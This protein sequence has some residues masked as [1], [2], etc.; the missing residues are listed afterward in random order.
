MSIKK[1]PLRENSHRGIARSAAVISLAALA[2]RILGFTRDMVIA[3]MF[4]IYV[5]AQAF[6]IAFKI[7]NLFRD[8]LAEGASNAAV[9][10]VL[11]EYAGKR[12]REEFWELANVVLNLLLII[13]S[14][15]TLAGVIFA[16][17][18]V[19]IAAP[20]FAASPEKLEAT[21]RLTRIIFPYI[22]L[23]SL[24]AYA[25]AILNSLKV[26]AFPAFAPCLLNISIIVCAL[27]FGEGIKGLASGVLA[28]GLLQLAAQVPLLYR[29]GFRPRLSVKLKHPA[30]HRIGRLML[31]RLLST[32]IYQLN[33][34]VD[35]IFG[36]LAGVVGEGGVAI[37]YFSYRLVQFPVGIFSNALAQAVLPV[38]A[39]Q[40]LDENPRGLRRTV[41]WG[42]R[43]V[44]FV[45]LP[46]SVGLGALA[47]PIVGVLFGGGRFDAVSAHLTADTLVFY[48]VGLWAYGATKMLQA[49]FFALK[50]TV[51]PTKVSALA[52]ALNVVLNSVFIFPL[53]TGGIALATSISGIVSFCVLYAALRRRLGDFHSGEIAASGL[54]ILAASAC[55]GFVAYFV[56]H[57]GYAPVHTRAGAAANLLLAI[58]AGVASYAGLC[59]VF[60]VREMGQ[61]IGLLRGRDALRSSL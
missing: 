25:T 8:V 33:N 52:L 39:T 21:I 15:L 40:A 43:A 34:F 22:I 55:M 31:P 42:V 24:A 54:R 32:S 9:V 16:P 61:L 30:A 38:L 13:L 60:R 28:G 46:A 23:V 29:R 36:S 44:F 10:P 51:T 20:G 26:F 6:V 12:S 41:S 49:S 48:S 50:D 11:C 59:V 3:R 4:G 45:M 2:S 35:T 53:K 5:Y 7:P 17:V 27:L 37:L 58:T 14:A 18:I 19:H 57:A 1:T 56:Y 47:V